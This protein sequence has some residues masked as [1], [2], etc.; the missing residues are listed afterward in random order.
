MNKEFIYK[1]CDNLIDQLTVLKGSIQLEKMNNKV[2]HSITILQEVANIEK[3]INELVHQLI[4][5][6]N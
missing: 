3:T 6:D 4:N 5:L 2:D 1:I